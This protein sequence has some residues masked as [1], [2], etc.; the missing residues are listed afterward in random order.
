MKP[1][2]G[3][4]LSN[5]GQEIFDA[6]RD[7]IVFGRLNPRERLVEADLVQRFDSH[8]AAVREALAAL[9]QA[10]LVDRQRNKGAAVLDL[11]PERVEQLYAV[12]ML[13]E[14]TAAGTMPLPLDPVALETLV[15]IQ[16]DH[17]QAVA[18]ND[19]RRIFDHNN[20]FHRTLYTQSGNPVLVELIEQCA[21]RALTVR[22]H[23]YMDRSFLERVCADHWAMIDACR[24][25]DRARLI[26][27][28]RD[29]LPLAKNRYLDTYDELLVQGGVFAPQA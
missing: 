5:S 28:V 10:G 22:F 1:G 4:S 19:L 21:T 23:P 29:H 14:T 25:C 2:P 7:D 24:L 16:Q 9:E 17:Q 26:A 27:L 11:K 15:S 13:L 8:R 20:R 6:L 3:S 18:D 12:R